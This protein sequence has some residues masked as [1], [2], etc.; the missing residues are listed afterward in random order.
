MRILLVDEHFDSSTIIA[1]WVSEFF[2]AVSVQWA[3]S[4]DEAL[5]AIRKSCPELVL[6]THRL[7]ALDGIELAGVIKA[8]PNPPVVVVICTGSDGAL[9]TQCAAAAGADF[10]V[11]KRHLQ[12][13]LLAFL[14]QRFPQAW[15]QGVLARRMSVK[16]LVYVRQHAV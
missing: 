16:S 15:A 13:R 9:E 6:A 3:P 5:K 1:D 10:Q 7:P 2:A 14:Q 11:E 4:C 12:A 8:Q